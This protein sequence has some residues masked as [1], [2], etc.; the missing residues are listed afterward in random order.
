MW[1]LACLH[2]PSSQHRHKE[3]PVRQTPQLKHIS[4]PAH[5]LEFSPAL[6]REAGQYL[7]CQECRET[8]HLSA[9]KA[10]C[11]P[12]SSTVSNRRG[13]PDIPGGCKRPSSCRTASPRS[14]PCL[15]DLRDQPVSRDIADTCRQSSKTFPS[16]S[17]C[18]QRSRRVRPCPGTSAGELG[19][20]PGHHPREQIPNMPAQLRQLSVC[21]RRHVIA[22]HATTPPAPVAATLASK[23]LDVISASPGSAAPRWP[24]RPATAAGPQHAQALATCCLCPTI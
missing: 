1:E 22:Y 3:G 11:S 23:R 10:P 5:P 20:Q 8:P 12:C 6:L 19:S 9:T 21:F 4:P 2:G 13:H 17:D 18:Y 16:L 7:R 15:L 24:T 14:S